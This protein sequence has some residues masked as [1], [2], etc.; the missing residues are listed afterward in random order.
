MY[1][2]Q[3]YI[4]GTD[5]LQSL[6]LRRI[7]IH[8]LI[9]GP[10]FGVE[11]LRALQIGLK[12]GLVASYEVSAHAGFHIYQ[13]LEQMPGLVENLIGMVNPLQ[14]FVQVEGFP[15]KQC[16]KGCHDHHGNHNHSAEQRFEFRVFHRTNHSFS[17]G[18]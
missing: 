10:V 4:A 11:S 6:L 17:E 9:Q 3:S 12:E 7:V 8:Q 18:E 16:G 15:Q 14:G 13:Q 1:P 2:T 5:V